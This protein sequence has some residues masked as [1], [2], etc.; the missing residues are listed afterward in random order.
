MKVT[1]SKCWWQ[2]HCVDDGIEVPDDSIE[3]QL[4]IFDFGHW[5]ALARTFKNQNISLGGIQNL[6]NIKLCHNR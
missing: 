3:N 4:Q 5:R 1:I 6:T 2:N